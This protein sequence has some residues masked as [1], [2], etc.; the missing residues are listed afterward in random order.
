MLG[1]NTYLKQGHLTARF[2]PIGFMLIA[3][4]LQMRGPGC[5][6]V[7]VVS[8]FFPGLEVGES[9]PDTVQARTARWKAASKPFNPTSLHWK[10]PE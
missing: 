6:T 2:F 1:L 4:A 7:H 10:L 8:L 9:C 3:V 5:V